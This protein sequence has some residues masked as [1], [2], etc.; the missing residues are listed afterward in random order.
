MSQDEQERRFD[1]QRK[2][3]EER[4]RQREDFQ[5]EKN[6]RQD[7]L[8]ASRSKQL[9]KRD[10]AMARERKAQ[11][12][13]RESMYEVSRDDKRQDIRAKQNIDLQIEREITQREI[14]LQQLGSL[15]YKQNLQ[16]DY[17]HDIRT[18]NLDV[19]EY[20][21]KTNIDLKKS[22]KELRENLKS[23]ILE[24]LATHAISE[25]AKN[26]AQ[27]REVERMAAESFHL[28]TEIRARN[29]AKE[30]EIWTQN[31]AN[32]DFEAFMM[33]LRKKYHDFSDEEISNIVRQM[34][35]PQTT[36]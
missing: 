26:T 2:Q 19:Q 27:T 5:R 6:E 7:R 10:E 17:E 23:N 13:H 9:E 1:F 18:R 28:V 25:S 8:D 12:T 33:E 30:S 32:K 14:M 16:S 20:Q 22:K 24:K 34:Q 29:R 11:R 3:Q 4:L 15:I 36:L 35:E 21:L 31:D